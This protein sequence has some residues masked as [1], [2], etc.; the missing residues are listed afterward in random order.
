MKLGEI[1]NIRTGLILSRKKSNVQT[2]YRYRLLNL[3]SI[4]PQGYI[5][6]EE[7][8][9]FDAK[10]Q[11]NTEYLTKTNDIIIRLSQPYT[12]VL[13]DKETEKMVISSN[14]LIIR[15]SSKNLLPAYLHWFLN[16]EKVKRNAYKSATSNMLSA[17]TP[18]YYNEL[19][20]IMPPK[21]KQSTIANLF[22]LSQR[23]QI[24]LEQLKNEKQKL[25]Q[26][27][28]YKIQKE[29]SKGNTK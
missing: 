15:N 21:E 10:E 6:K 11:L 14:F 7:L 25:N 9:V 1:V 8:D 18:Q 12:A 26:I 27:Q 2:K 19:S 16:T 3:K 22:T 13:I 24:L 20:I 23:E 29:I 28:T 5:N 4:D 17:I